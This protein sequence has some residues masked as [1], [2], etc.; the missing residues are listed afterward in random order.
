MKLFSKLAAVAALAAASSAFAVGPGT[1]FASIPS[2]GVANLPLK[3]SINGDLVLPQY[4]GAQPL[5]GIIVALSGYVTSS[6]SFTNND[7]ASVDYSIDLN[8]TGKLFVPSTTTVLLAISPSGPG[9]TGTLGAGLGTNFGPLVGTDNGSV[10]VAP[11][12][13][14]PYLGSGDVTI[15]YSL[16]GSAIISGGSNLTSTIVTQGSLTASVTYVVPEPAAL[17]L[18]APA[19]TLLGRRRRA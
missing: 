18:I 7:A 11:A 6:G 19:A 9:L 13:W 1:Y 12:G 15:P 8:A 10:S 3:P 2:E 17:G 16:L 14:A 5:Q 4:D